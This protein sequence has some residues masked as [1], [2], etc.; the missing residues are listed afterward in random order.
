[1]PRRVTGVYKQRVTEPALPPGR[2]LVTT[3]HLAMH[4]RPEHALRPLPEGTRVDA[5]PSIPLGFYR[6]LYETVGAPW[7][8]VDRRMMGD[9]ELASLVHAEG[10]EVHVAYADGAPAGYFE[11]DA[12]EAGSVELAYFGVVPAWIGRG[13]GL[14]LL[15][16]AVQ[17]AWSLPGTARVWVHTCSL[18]HPRA[19]SMY[20]RAGFT[21]FHVHDH[22]EW[23]PR[24]LPI[25][26]R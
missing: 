18:D 14:S 16:R 15:Q 13:L 1:M 11:L 5:A 26:P 4:A 22:E 3:W 9:A 7:C 17:R 6:Y 21:T 20:E 25:S 12:R 10:V 19:K 24:P 23:D 2:I 8:W